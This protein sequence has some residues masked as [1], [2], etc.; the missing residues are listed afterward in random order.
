MSEDTLITGANGMLG[1]ELREHFNNPVLLQGRSDIDL[2][3]TKV[4][5]KFFKN[6]RFKQ[7]IHCAAFT[8]LNYCE[9]N[10]LD[11]FFL[12]AG[13]IPF[14]RSKCDKLIYISTNPSA[15]SKVYYRS[16]QKGELL[17]AERSSDLVVRV[18]IYGNGGLS[19]WA[20]TSLAKKEVINGY[21]NVYF[22]PVS[23]HQLSKFL[24]KKS[25]KYQGI[26]NVGANK[27]VRKYDFI[28]MLAKKLGFDS[29]L[30]NATEIQGDESVLDLTVPLKNQYFKYSLRRGINQYVKHILHS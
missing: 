7:I 23:V 13:I 15:S 10:P 14:L 20:L 22:N 11:T 16:K 21:S 18:N 1:S 4:V 8:D 24:S 2:T 25:D 28:I 17:T 9:Q 19:K 30:I 29:N 26:V 12:H 5:S 6:K 3:K 27:K